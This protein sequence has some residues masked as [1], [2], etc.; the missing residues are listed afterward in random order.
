[1]GVDDIEPRVEHYPD[2]RAGELECGFRISSLKSIVCGN[3]LQI[4]L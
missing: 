4:L 3:H 1:M 2:D